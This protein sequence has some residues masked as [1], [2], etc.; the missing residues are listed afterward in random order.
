LKSLKQERRPVMFLDIFKENVEKGFLVESD[1]EEVLEKGEKSLSGYYDKYNEGWKKEILNELSIKG[2]LL[3]AVG[4]E[5]TLSGNLDKVEILEGD[6][7]K[8]IDY[9]TGKIRS[10]NVLEGKTKNATGDYKRQL[11]FYKLL[12]DKYNKGQYKMTEGEINFIEPNNN[13]QYKKELFEISS[14]EVE[15][16]EEIVK[17][18]TKEILDLSFWDKKCDNKDCEF[19]KLREAME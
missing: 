17:N 11:I 3:E 13:G 9:K 16:L 6:R 15:E 19:C 14:E 10:R 8:V 18:I 1:K 7:V 2:V 5:I 4:E 12:L